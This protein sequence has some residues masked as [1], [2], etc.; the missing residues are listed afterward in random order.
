MRSESNSY[1]SVNHVS[2]AYLCKL[3]SNPCCIILN[4]QWENEHIYW[5]PKC[6][7]LYLDRL[8]PGETLVED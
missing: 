1:L 7:D 5:D 6:S 3:L 4:W 2:L 8:K